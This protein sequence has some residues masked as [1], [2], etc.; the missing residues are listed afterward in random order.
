M[1][2]ELDFLLISHFIRISF[3]MKLQNPL[4]QKVKENLLTWEKVPVRE[5]EGWVIVFT[6]TNHQP[7][8]AL[9]HVILHGGL[10]MSCRIHINSRVIPHGSY[11]FAFD[12]A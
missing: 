12:S 4:F 9:D 5:V 1:K 8:A 11:D 7:V 6:P 2:N 3:C 10:A